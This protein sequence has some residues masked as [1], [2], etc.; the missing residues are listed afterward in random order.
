M[1]TY[2]ELCHSV[3]ILGQAIEGSHTHRNVGQLTSHSGHV[4][5]KDVKVIQQK[6]NTVVT[7]CASTPNNKIVTT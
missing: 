2:P 5:I 3:V 4:T 1:D 7:L 6:V